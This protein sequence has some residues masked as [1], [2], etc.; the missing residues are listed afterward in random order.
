A[1]SC[2]KIPALLIKS[3]YQELDNM[4]NS[5]CILCFSLQNGRQPAVA[6]SRFVMR[7]NPTKAH[8]GGIG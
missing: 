4:N 1:L 5:S 2:S 6:A 7:E 3:F 8:L